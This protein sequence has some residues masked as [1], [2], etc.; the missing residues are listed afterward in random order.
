MKTKFIDNSLNG[1]YLRDILKANG[2]TIH[3]KKDGFR[4]Y[5]QEPTGYYDITVPV[6]QVILWKIV[7]GH[8]YKVPSYSDYSGK[9]MINTLNEFL[10]G[11]K[12]VI[13]MKFCD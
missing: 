3:I 6:G 1:N 10:Y 13:K 2:N 9:Y 4:V 5:V 7:D 12:N 11:K 8:R